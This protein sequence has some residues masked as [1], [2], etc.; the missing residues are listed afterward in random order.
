MEGTGVTQQE[1]LEPQHCSPLWSTQQTSD[2]AWH[3]STCD[4]RG[5]G[6]SSLLCNALVHGHSAGID[7]STVINAEMLGLKWNLDP[8]LSPRRSNVVHCHAAG[9]GTLQ[10]RTCSSLQAVCLNLKQQREKTWDGTMWNSEHD[11]KAVHHKP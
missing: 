4:N 9:D 11:Y 1:L 10:K 2:C 6:D 7:Y 8:V 3:P 5:K